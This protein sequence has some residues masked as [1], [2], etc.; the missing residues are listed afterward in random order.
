MDRRFLPARRAHVNRATLI[1]FGAV[2]LWAALALL[3]TLSGSAP[4]LLMN[5]ICFGVG[6]AVGVI[7][8]RLGGV[9]LRAAARQPL[10]V[11]AIGVGGLFGYHFVYF[12][13]LRNA[14]GAEAQASLIAYLWPLLI[15]LFSALLPGERL[16]AIQVIGALLGF[17]GAALIVLGGEGFAV[18]PRHV[19]GY[20]AAGLCALIWSGYSV[21]SRRF[22]TAPTETV[23]LFCAATAV[24]SLLAHL[25]LEET[26]WPHGVVEWG[27]TIL[28]GLGPVG[29]AFY[30]WDYGVKRG[31]IQVLGVSS[32]AAP[33]LS[34]LMMAAA[35][36][37]AL[38]M[39]L[40]LACLLIVGGAA[41]AALGSKA[42]RAADQG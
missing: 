9:S 39:R 10:A 18:D 14:P 28:L 26:I 31:D 42:T 7:D 25:A 12:T 8:A 38:D 16:R 13:A 23:T 32:Y 29:A 21:L 3:T 6:A 37:A 35:G 34:T 5:A 22:G 2:L 11:W 36:K 41:L 1:G 4:P 24:L 40:G 30:L 19:V 20:G 17:A 15:V 33:L 27:A